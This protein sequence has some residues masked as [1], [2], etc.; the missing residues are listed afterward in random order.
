[1]I[2]S[3]LQGVKY[4]LC[5]ENI[6]GVSPFFEQA[7]QYLFIN[8]YFTFVFIYSGGLTSIPQALFALLVTSAA[9]AILKIPESRYAA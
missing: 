4:A 2:L 6:K 9:H 5:T 8:T 3:S 1:M 7:G